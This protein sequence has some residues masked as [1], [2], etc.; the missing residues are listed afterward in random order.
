MI[1]PEVAIPPARLRVPGRAP[2]VPHSA[3]LVSGSGTV[4]MRNIVVPYISIRSP[5]PWAPTLSASDQASI[6]PVMTGMPSGSPVAAAASA[7]TVPAAS[8]GHCS[9][10][11]SMAPAI[12]SAHGSCQAC[13][14]QS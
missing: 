6:V 10:G 9:G 11:S 4:W 2:T 1:A 12:S 14:T 13:S 7:L 5:T 3:G 8:P